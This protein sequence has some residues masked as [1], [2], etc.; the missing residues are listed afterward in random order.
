MWDSLLIQELLCFYVS[1]AGYW[2]LALPTE[3]LFELHSL[4]EG[5]GVG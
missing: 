4:S 2:L 3:A 5:G 1:G